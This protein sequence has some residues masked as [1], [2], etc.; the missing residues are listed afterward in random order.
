MWYKSF[1]VLGLIFIFILIYN[2]VL[3]FLFFYHPDWDL[4][5]SNYFFNGSEFIAAHSVFL[6][7]LRFLMNV[8]IWSLG[9]VI[10][11]LFIILFFKKI[12]NLY[13]SHVFHI[14]QRACLYL[15]FCF[16]M[17]PGVVTNL[18]LKNH[19]GQPRPAEIINFGGSLVYQKVWEVSSACPTNCAFVCGDCASVFILFAFLPLLIRKKYYLFSF[20]LGLVISFA[21]LG[22]GWI[23]IAQGGHF[24]S[25]VLLSYGINALVIWVGYILFFIFSRP[26]VGL[27]IDLG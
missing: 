27:V 16:L 6:N 11:L 19:M 23:R 26:R 20:L 2:A 14:S 22:M 7:Q 25:D 21:A 4:K 9:G 8:L 10:F 12:N 15:L 24:L 5:I 3:S 17:G 13:I 1:F 18:I